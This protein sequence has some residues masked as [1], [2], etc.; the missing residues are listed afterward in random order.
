MLEA[1]ERRCAYLALYLEHATG[2]PT[3]D[4]VLPKSRVWDQIY[5]WSNYRLCA[6]LINTTVLMGGRLAIMNC[7]CK[8]PKATDAALRREKWDAARKNFR[9]KWAEEFGT[10]P[11]QPDGTRWPGHHIRDL[12]YGGDPVAE[13]NVLP[14]RPD[15]HDI[16]SKEYPLC[17]SGNSQWSKVGIDRPYID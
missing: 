14:V 13:N 11:S 5:E 4:H 6:A 7:C 10:W 15:V 1:Y 16:F 9:E 2:N 17:Y 3:V 8:Y 12:R